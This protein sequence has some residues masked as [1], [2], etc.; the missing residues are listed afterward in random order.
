[1]PLNREAKRRHRMVVSPACHGEARPSVRRPL[2]QGR[3]RMSGLTG[4]VD[5][6]TGAARRHHH[7]RTEAFQNHQSSTPRKTPY[8]PAMLITRPIRTRVAVKPAARKGTTFQRS[9]DD[10]RKTIHSRSRREEFEHT[11]RRAAPYML[12]TATLAPRA[13]PVE[14]LPGHTGRPS[15]RDSDSC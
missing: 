11:T 7:R 5:P 15:R 2:G 9:D 1:M 8:A 12:K 3:K 13:I 10:T 4:P 6:R 14:E